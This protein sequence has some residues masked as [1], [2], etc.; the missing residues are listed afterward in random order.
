MKDEELAHLWRL[1]GITRQRLRELEAQ[2]AAYG[3]HRAPAEVLI[4]LKTSREELER[5]E[6][7]IRTPSISPEVQ[8]ATGPEAYIDVLRVKVDHLTDFVGTAFRQVT[9]ELLE[10]KDDNRRQYDDMEKRRESGALRYQIGFAIVGVTII[11]MLMMMAWIIG[12]LPV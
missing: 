8:E 2:A 10:V 7:K 5:L 11:L 6:A 1:R 4:E 3:P 12:R 9:A